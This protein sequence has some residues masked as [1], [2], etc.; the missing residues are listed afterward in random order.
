[1]SC[2]KPMYRLE[3]TADVMPAVKSIREYEKRM[4]YSKNSDTLPWLF[5]YQDD[6]IYL[7]EKHGIPEF[8]FTQVPCGHCMGC[9]IDFQN[10]W[11]AR[12]MYEASLYDHNC[13]VTLTYDTKF[14]PLRDAIDMQSGQLFAHNIPQLE[15]TDLQKFFKRLRFWCETH[16][17]PSPRYFASGEYGDT[18]YRPHYHAIIFNL[19][20]DD[21]QLLYY[22][23]GSRKSLQPFPGGLPFFTSPILENLW[24]KG[25]ITISDVTPQSCAY[26]ASYV[27]K[28]RKP[29]AV[30]SEYYKELSSRLAQ[31]A[32][33]QGK[34]EDLINIGAVTSPFCVMSRRPGIA[35][36]FWEQNREKILAGE[37]PMVA[38]QKMRVQ[39]IRYF[40]AKFKTEENTMTDLKVKMNK[41]KRASKARAAEKMRLTSLT[42][43]EYREQREA[44]LQDK[45]KH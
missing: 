18:G 11:S 14:L 13:F 3:L 27:S 30:D 15:I 29:P 39:K 2:N 40:D 45:L 10:E 16:N 9:Y 42:P 26:V 41:A 4:R 24:G 17:K 25:F 19:R 31:T 5:L 20:L 43:E 44:R 7:K 21:L 28:K 35:S 23:K 32:P 34:F 38:G 22:A 12:C 8:K 33:V 36:E 1:M 6:Y 37:L